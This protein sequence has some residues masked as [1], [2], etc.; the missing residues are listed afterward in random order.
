MRLSSNRNTGNFSIHHRGGP[1]WLP[2]FNVSSTYNHHRETVVG[3][4]SQ[5]LFG[6]LFL[7]SVSGL[8]WPVNLDLHCRSGFPDLKSP[9]LHCRSGFSDLKSPDLHCRS[10]FPDL[11]NADLHCQSGFSNLKSLDLHCQSGFPDLKSPDLHCRSDFSDLKSPD[12]HCRSG[13]P[14]LK[15]PDRHCRWGG[16]SEFISGPKGRPYV[17]SSSS[18]RSSQSCPSRL[19]IYEKK[20]RLGRDVR[21]GSFISFCC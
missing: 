3:S 10:G 6:Q 17:C 2:F 8:S 19:G 20:P 11:K 14:D 16:D 13:F 7:H 21:R 9:D 5:K 12:L 15:S 4:L 18:R 1:S